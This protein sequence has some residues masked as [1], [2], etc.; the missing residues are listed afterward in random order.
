MDITN[1]DVTEIITQIVAVPDYRRCWRH[2]RAP[3]L[4]TDHTAPNPHNIHI[5]PPI[6]G[7]PRDSRTQREVH[8]TNSL[9]FC[10][11]RRLGTD[12][13]M[14]ARLTKSKAYSDALAEKQKRR[15][16]PKSSTSK[17]PKP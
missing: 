9:Q 11:A 10:R 8:S 13:E 15:R 2:C 12:E 14:L 1:G 6:P 17:V 4:P 7:A 5:L 16:A 3:A